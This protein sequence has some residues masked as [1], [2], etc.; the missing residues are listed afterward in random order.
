MLTEDEAHVIGVLKAAEIAAEKIPETTCHTPDLLAQDER[1]RY[2]VEVKRRKD[3]ETL[4]REL[5]DVGYGYRE[6]PIAWTSTVASILQ[7]AANQKRPRC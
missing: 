7:V 6:S 1:N 4:S 2:V 5:Q 3:D